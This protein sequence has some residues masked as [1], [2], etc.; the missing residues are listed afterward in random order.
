[1]SCQ[2][3]KTICPLNIFKPMPCIPNCFCPDPVIYPRDPCIPEY[4]QQPP[5][6]ISRPCNLPRYHAPRISFPLCANLGN[7]CCWDLTLC[8]K[9]CQIPC[10]PH[11]TNLD[12]NPYPIPVKKNVCRDCD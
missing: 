12:C 9:P 6:P 11:L 1:M 5:R 3:K 2:A 10:L 7:P 4:F 8:M